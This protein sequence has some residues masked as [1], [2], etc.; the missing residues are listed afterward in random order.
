MRIPRIL[1]RALKKR[2]LFLDRYRE[3]KPGVVGLTIVLIIVFLA[4]FAPFLAPNDP[5]SQ[6][7]DLYKPPSFQHPF[8]TD[9]LGRDVL[10]RIIYGTRVT[11]LIAVLSST[12][13][14]A[15]G[16]ILG[17]ISG[18]FG[19]MIDDILSRGFD[20]V[21]LTPIFFLLIIITSLLGTSV[22]LVSLVIGVTIWPRTA[23]LMRSQV[24]SLK[25]RTFVEAST[26]SGASGLRTLFTHVVPN[27]LSPVI[28]NMA[29]QSAS[30][31]LIEA[32]LSFLGLGD[33]NV[34][35]WGQM[36]YIGARTLFFGWWLALIPGLAIAIAVLGFNLVADGLSY[37]LH[38][39]LEG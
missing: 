1:S 23:R 15:L 33:Q 19:G 17:A 4:I 12:L 11:L 30:A 8:G 24:L 39:Q 9:S 26:V 16:T 35:S 3:S 37:A 6:S 34:V 5:F 2:S 38:P 25:E 27:G 13:S 10:S 28:A 22:Y 14:T 36:V 21:Y 32:G 29:L 31:I 7:Q 20:V 18:W